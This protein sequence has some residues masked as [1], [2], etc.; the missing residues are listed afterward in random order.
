MSNSIAAQA[1]QLVNQILWDAPETTFTA[2]DERSEAALGTTEGKVI[3]A[4]I[5]M[6]HTR[7][8]NARAKYE[9][10]VA[11]V[12]VIQGSG[13]NAIYLLDDGVVGEN[14]NQAIVWNS[15]GYWSELYSHT[16]NVVACH[17]ESAGLDI[18][19]RLGYSIY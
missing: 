10:L 1:D 5:T 7:A 19:A 2:L 16:C 15:V 3:D 11:D 13:R 9:K 18:N 8:N 4:A 14:M 6:L 17:A 12:E